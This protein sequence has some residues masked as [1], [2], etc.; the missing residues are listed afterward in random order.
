MPVTGYR[1]EADWDRDAGFANA[2]SNITGYVRS[3]QY[4]YGFT[5]KYAEMGQPARCTIVLDNHDG[6]WNV[7]NTGSLF[8]SLYRKGVLIRVGT[9]IDT[10]SGAVFYPSFNGRIV[11]LALT[12]GVYEQGNTAVLTVECPTQELIDA[13]YAPEL[14]T[15]LRTDQAIA[16]IF[17]RAIVVYPYVKEYW[18]LG[19]TSASVLGTSTILFDQGIANFEAGDTTIPYVGASGDEGEGLNAYSFIQNCVMAEAGGRFFWDAALGQFVFWKRS[20]W[21]GAYSTTAL[22]DSM[23]EVE[24]P[25]TFHYGDDLINHVEVEYELRKVGTAGSMLFSS[26]QVPFTLT[27]GQSRQ[28]VGY[29]RDPDIPSAR[30]S[31]LTTI[32]PVRGTDFI[33]NSASDG[34]GTDKTDKLVVSAEVAA[35]NVNIHV[36]ND[37]ASTI[38]VTKLQ[39]RGTPLTT[40]QRQKVS[41]IDADSI[42]DYGLHKKL[43]S[44]YFVEDLAT[45]TSAAQRYRD[46]FKSPVRRIDRVTVNYLNAPD[47][48]LTLEA[49]QPMGKVL[50]YNSTKLG[51]TNGDY[52][53]T[54]IERLIVPGV[55]GVSGTDL[56]TY[57]L[58]PVA[59]WTY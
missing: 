7:G 28:I 5:Q 34:S 37:D 1:V 27:S 18:V 16:R 20:K 29:Y 54:G 47:A 26:E 41:A 10:G 40:Y 24:Q 4:V 21:N 6:A 57:L 9:G 35:N 58:E 2:N 39:V 12:P 49:T 13:E 30:I 31:A 36:V 14:E 32:T 52:I 42:A 17:S 53:I 50:R 22:N 44:M 55:G 25:L 46:R 19:S 15:N 59:R 45:V 38:Y 43:I 56:N 51:I 3:I 23:I 33:A 11:D 8:Y 48:L